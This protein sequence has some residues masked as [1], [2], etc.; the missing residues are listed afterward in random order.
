M[1]KPIRNLLLIAFLCLAQP[2]FSQAAEQ[3]VDSE[4][5]LPQ[6]LRGQKYQLEYAGEK[7]LPNFQIDG[8]PAQ[9]HT[10]GIYVTKQSLYVTGRLERKSRRAL[11]LRFA[12]PNLELAEYLDITPPVDTKGTSAGHL[13]HPGGFDYD[14]TCFWIPVAVSQRQ[15]STAIVKIRTKLD[16]E[17]TNVSFETAFVLNDHIGALAFDR[18]RDRL[19]GANWDTKLVYVWQRDGKLLKRIPREELLEGQPKWSLAVQ[20]W[21]GMSEGILL[22]GGL[23]KSPLRNPSQPRAVVQWIDLSKRQTLD[24]IRLPSPSLEAHSMT[25]EGMAFFEQQIFLL[26]GDLGEDAALYRYR[27][28]SVSGL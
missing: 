11:L 18:K 3:K 2:L 16:S 10:Q 25:H 15:S 13:D 23:D 4:D 21:K 27:V 22:A 24:T 8:E 17:L 12:R 6:V 5:A 1:S 28:E 26:P 19:F 9:I 14:G 7:K 20:D